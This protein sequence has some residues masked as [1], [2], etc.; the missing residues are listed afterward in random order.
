MAVMCVRAGGQVSFDDLSLRKRL[1]GDEHPILDARG[2]LWVQSTVEG[3]LHGD[4]I[5]LQAAKSESGRQVH[6]HST[7]ARV[8]DPPEPIL[9]GGWTIRTNLVDVAERAPNPV[10]RLRGNVEPRRTVMRL[11]ARVVILEIVLDEPLLSNDLLGKRFV[12]RVGHRHHFDR[13]E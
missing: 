13:G 4:V 3:E 7:K 11:N 8:T 2:E 12:R 6:L 9:A 1:V 10:E 5:S